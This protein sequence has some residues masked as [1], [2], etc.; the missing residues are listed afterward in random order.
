MNKK[1][2]LNSNGESHVQI[3]ISQFNTGGKLVGKKKMDQISGDFNYFY[4]KLAE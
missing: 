4:Y 2:N 1:S 3:I